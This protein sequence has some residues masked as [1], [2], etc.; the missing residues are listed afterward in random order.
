MPAC[1]DFPVPDGGK[2]QW[3]G[4]NLRYNGI[5]MQIQELVSDMTPQQLIGYYKGRWGRTPPGFHEYEAG[6]WQVIATI[7]GTCFFT[8]QVQARGRGSKALL[9][10]SARPDNGQVKTPGAGFPVPGGT[11][12]VNDID[13]FDGGKTGRTLLLMNSHSTDMNAHYYRRTLAGDGWVPIVDRTVQTA[14]GLSHVMVLK[15]GH[16]EANLSISPDRA[17]TSVVVNMVDRP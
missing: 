16:H 15:R 5:P 14:R 4:A 12:V 1:A 11:L 6:D 9:G 7:R 17:G 10:I 13:H 8:V 3:V 2:L